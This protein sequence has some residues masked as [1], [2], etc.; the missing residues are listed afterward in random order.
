MSGSIQF[1]GAAQNVTGSSYLLQVGGTRVLVDCGLYQE[2]DFRSR[3]WE[4]FPV[5]PS[6]VDAVLLTHAH[7]DH[8][9]LL[10]KLVREG[11]RGPIYGTAPTAD[12]ARIVLLDSAKIQEED[13]AFKRKR[14]A[15]ENR[16]GPFPLEPLYTIEDAERCIRR[17]KVITEGE[18]LKLGDGLEATFHTAGHILG[19]SMIQARV[20]RNGDAR[21]VLF[22]GDVGR[23]DVPIL[24]DPT[25]FEQAD[26]VICESTYGN[27]LHE[28][29]DVVPDKLARIINETRAAGGNLVIPAFAVERTQELLYRLSDLLAQNR[30]PHLTAFVDSP[31]AVRVTE[32]FQRHPECFDDD[33]LAKLKAGRHPCDFP[34]LTMTRTSE[35][36][37]AINH[38]RGTVIVMAGSGMCEGGRIKHHLVNNISRPESTILFV[39]YQAVGTL[40]R[41]ILEKPAEVRI[42]G[43]T[44]PVR[45]RIA[46]IN[47]FSGHADR[48]ELFRWLSALKQAPRQLFLTHGEASVAAEFAGWLRERTKW[49][50]SVPAYLDKVDIL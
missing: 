3:N 11:F 20:G 13:I 17:F 1:L 8:A 39:G 35:E 49:N 14:H 48:D 25:L 29:A 28:T 45:A 33:M 22:S 37:K 38:I 34:G 6:S 30:V 19:A 12:I 41:A 7:G 4:P 23:W 27:R 50:V 40:G 5:E 46:K 31:M 10:P 36:S 16:A 44:Y 43:Q 24:K 9:G 26:Y 15:K 42:L 2:R 32:V 47:G 18:P 21:T